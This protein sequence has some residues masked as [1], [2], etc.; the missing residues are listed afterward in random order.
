MAAP[1]PVLFALN[2]S[3]EPQ[4]FENLCVDLLV[5]E[6]HS[7]IIPGGKS[8]D[9][10]RD[11]EVR[12]W[13]TP[14]RGAPQIAFQFSMETKWEPKLRKDISKIT[15]HNDSIDRIVFVSSRSITVEKQDKLR[16]EFRVSHQI[17]LEILDE[18]WFRIRLE[19]DHVDLALKHLGVVVP[20]TPGF[21]ATQI[22]LYGLNDE[23]QEEMLRHRS[24]QELRATFT[25]QTQADPSNS[26]AWKGLAHICYYLREYENALLFT[27]KALRLSQDGVER[28]N[29]IALKASIIAEQ[30]I[31]SGSRLLLKQAKELFTPFINQL[32]RSI[33]HYNL[34]NILGALKQREEA[35][36]HYRLCLELDPNCAQAWKNLG[37][38]LFELRRPDEG[39]TCID[40]ALELKP[41]LLEA[42][43]TKANILVMSSN[44]CAEALQ[45]IELAFELD[46]DLETRWPH[47]HYWHA[48]ALCRENRLPEA[49][50]IVEDRLERK[51]DCP[52]L[53][54]LA[55]DILAKL[56]R[57]D[58]NYIAKAEEFFALRIDP[59]ERNY[60]ALIEM[61]DLLA[62]SNREDDAWSMLEKFLEVEKLSI[63]LI[64]ER[65]PLSISDLADSFASLEYY[66]RFRGA[67]SLADY[68][69]MLDECGL[70]P[71][72]D[73]PEILF[74][75]LLPA[76]FKMAAALQDSDSQSESNGELE[77]LL[78]TYQLVSRTFAAFGGAILSPDVPETIEK[79]TELMAG[80]VAIGFDIPLIEVSRLLGFLCGVANR[81]I[82]ERY[83]DAMVQS[84]GAIHETWLT[85]FFR[86]VGSDWK[87]EALNK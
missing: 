36:H 49:L 16:D 41:D 29:L 52:Y 39:M 35:E 58:P 34:A 74:H 60:R 82:P 1:S 81:E 61:L 87:I 14:K 6:G 10:G 18:G 12:Y 64:A 69:H 13:I 5:R 19:E 46:P 24:P 75:L 45:L 26:S 73:V 71:H 85:D 40:R 55:N 3:V 15:A 86:A 54:R 63:R 68:A 67:S 57:S 44:D 25:A 56:W 79:Q 62:A 53:G 27:S 28:W 21:Y 9:H 70:R 72:D 83:R 30:G 38:L 20:P 65:I 22:K 31:S 33:D 48:L 37:S 80:A 17:S 2:H 78:E 11:A 59:K 42:L 8:R 76:Y 7:R 66:R 84:T 43:C 50:T 32:G 23:N 51:F 4:G 77:V 47:A